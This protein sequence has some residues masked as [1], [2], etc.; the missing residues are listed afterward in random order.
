[1]HL[2]VVFLITACLN[3]PSV[4][5]YPTNSTSTTHPMTTTLQPSQDDAHVK[6]CRIIA[7]SMAAVGIFFPCICLCCLGFCCCGIMAGSAA[8]GMHSR[9]GDVDGGS[10]FACMQSAGAGG[11]N[12]CVLIISMCCSLGFGVGSW[13]ACTHAY[14]LGFFAGL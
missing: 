3:M 11:M 2:I 8:A 10:C 7:G 4:E 5:G 9:I 1:M 14:G 6:K 12:P 13:Y